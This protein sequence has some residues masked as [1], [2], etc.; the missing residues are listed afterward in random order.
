MPIEMNVKYQIELNSKK[1]TSVACVVVLWLCSCIVIDFEIWEH[2]W[3][4]C[5]CV[6]HCLRCQHQANA[7]MY[8]QNVTSTWLE[9]FLRPMCRQNPRKYCLMEEIRQTTRDF[10]Q[11]FL[12][13]SFVNNRK[14]YPSTDALFQPSTL[15]GGFNPLSKKYDSIVKNWIISLG[16]KMERKLIWVATTNSRRTIF[17]S[18]RITRPTS[19]QRLQKLLWSCHISPSVASESSHVPSW[20]LDREALRLFFPILVKAGMLGGEKVLSLSMTPTRNNKNAI[21][22]EQTPEGYE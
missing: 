8:H 11:G 18:Q 21:E 14:N 9:P 19:D 17:F 13:E 12:L 2:A 10:Y 7:E 22:N 16:L 20:P 6:M 5:T 4:F 3:R 1:K 15:I